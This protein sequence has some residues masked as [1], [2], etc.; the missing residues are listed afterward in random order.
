MFSRSVFPRSAFSRSAVCGL[1]F[2]DNP[3]DVPSLQYIFNVWTV[4]S[5]VSIQRRHWEPLSVR[6]W[7]RTCFRFCYY[8]NYQ[9]IIGLVLREG[10]TAF[11]EVLLSS[12]S[13]PNIDLVLRGDTEAFGGTYFT[14]YFPN[15]TYKPFIVLVWDRRTSVTSYSYA[16]RF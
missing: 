6:Y 10:K 1:C 2:L 5:D 7:R 11:G 15:T 12:F 9:P 13:Q 16:L 4:S 8:Y 3:I 14:L